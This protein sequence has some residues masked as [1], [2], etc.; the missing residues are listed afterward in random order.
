MGMA[1]F[2][3]LEREKHQDSIYFALDLCGRQYQKDEVMAWIETAAER[4]PRKIRS[5]AA[6][7]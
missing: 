7:Y 4:C 1:R 5:P 3:S 2:R 6:G